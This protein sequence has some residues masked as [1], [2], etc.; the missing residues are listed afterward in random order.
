MRYV[1]DTFSK[2]KR[3]QVDSF[4]AHLNAQHP[5][6]KFTTET[7]QNGQIAFLD[8]LVHR[9]QNGSIKVTIYRKAT[10]TDQYLDWTLNQHLSQKTGIIQTFKNRIQTLVTN[11][12]DQQSE[13]QHAKRALKRC[14]HPTWSLR[15]QNPTH[16]TAS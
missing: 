14:G 11:Q 13:L 4:L 2:L 12:S 6:I 16:Q 8:A 9:Q 15:A 10:H 5:R 3:H 7:E 1:D